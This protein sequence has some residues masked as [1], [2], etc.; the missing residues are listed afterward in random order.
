MIS[1]AAMHLAHDIHATRACVRPARLQKF[2]NS[3]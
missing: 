1:E 3:F 2:V